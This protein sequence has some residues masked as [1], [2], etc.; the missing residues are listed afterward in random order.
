MSAVT[1]ARGE[2]RAA[3]AIATKDLR[4]VRR[5]PIA[6][7]AWIFT[8]LYQ[9]VIPAFLFGAA[10]AVGSRLVGLEASVGTADLAGFIFMGGVIGGLVSVAFWS[11]AFSFRNE[12]EQGTLEPSWLTPTRHETF[13]IGRALGSLVPFV[14]VQ[15]ILFVFGIAFFG[16]RVSPSIVLASPA[17]VL[18]VVAMVGVAH[19]LAAAVLLMKEANLFIDATQFL[20]S[21][22][23]GTAFPI[24]VLPAVLQPVALLL[25][26]TY[27][28]D[29]LRQQALG[30]RTLF[31]PAAEYA[32]LAALAVVL[33]PFGRWV[34]ARADARLRRTG[35]LAQH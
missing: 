18:A 26:T 28:V 16:L 14:L 24:T 22:G 35:G 11:M 25:P 9:G 3:L 33:L 4:Q 5:Y 29:L 17:V 6:F 15:V 8:S 12:M 32:I 1:S 23:S 13:V 20:F 27:A 30:S 10:F 2:V 34:F 21:A 19:L 7:V 31:D